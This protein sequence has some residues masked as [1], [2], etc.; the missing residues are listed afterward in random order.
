[1]VETTVAEAAIEIKPARPADRLSRRELAIVFVLTFVALARRL[2]MLR[3]PA[4]M[5]GDHVWYTVLGQRLISGNLREGLSMYWPPLYPVLVGAFSAVFGNAELA[6]RLVSVVSGS[7][8]VAAEY[9][10]VRRL[11]G[12]NAACIAA[13]LTVVYPMLVEYS[14]LGLTESVYTLMFT[15]ALLSGLTAVFNGK[16]IR[17]FLTGVLIGACYLLKP[18]AFGF[19]GLFVLITLGANLAGGRIKMSGP[20]NALIFLIGFL[21]VSLPYVLYLRAETGRWG[22]SE[23][24]AAGLGQRQRRERELRE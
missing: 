17:F 4:E 12:K 1:V 14:T 13:F 9:L 3:H 15:L 23:K 8:L 10:F 5:S 21:L 7:L 18:E 16:W 22:I 6:G 19:A 2:F 24:L 11:Y 20:I